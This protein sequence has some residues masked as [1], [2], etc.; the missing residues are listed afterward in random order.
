MKKKLFILLPV[1]LVTVLCVLALPSCGGHREYRRGA[2]RYTVENGEATITEYVGTDANVTVPDTIG[3]KPVVAIG[4]DAF[5]DQH[6]LKSVTIPDSVIRIEFSAF[7]RCGALES[8]T[9]GEGIREIDALVFSH[10]D[11]LTY[12]E[13][14][15][16]SYLGSPENPYLALVRMSPSVETAVF[17]PDTRIICG[18]A[19]EDCDKLD[20]LIIPEGILSIGGFALPSLNTVSFPATMEHI[21]GLAF[22]DCRTPSEI[23]VAEGNTAYKSEDGNLFSY[24]GTRLIKYAGGKEDQ[25]YTVPDGTVI[26]E[27]NA[28]ESA[29]HLTEVTL[30]D[31]VEEIQHQAFLHCEGLKTLSLGNGLKI[32]GGAAFSYCKSLT[33]VTIPDSVEQ[34]N[35]F[36]FSFCEKLERVV[37]GSGVTHLGD[38][39][40][41]D[42][43]A[44][45]EV[46]FR[47][48]DG[49]RVS[50]MY[51]LTSKKVDLSDP[52]QNADYLTGEYCSYFWENN[53]K[54]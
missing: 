30:P 51:S 7:F 29:K 13:Y 27:G 50:A 1:L 12:N 33:E 48:P 8:V 15:N 28:F 34:V 54:D 31:S 53:S 42:C 39:V 49:W 20:D 16:G 19:F 22:S 4:T 37:I 32:I 36:T 43:D 45:T 52:E 44:L 24:D 38:E 46:V 2:Y 25:T 40:F 11:K 17:H 14:E 10:C 47:D 23:I 6:S 26:I 18:N 21:D 5:M 3:G 35:Y 9:L 41:Y